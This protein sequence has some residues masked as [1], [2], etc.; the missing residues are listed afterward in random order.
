[1]ILMTNFTLHNEIV[2]RYIPRVYRIRPSMVRFIDLF[3]WD[4]NINI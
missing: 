2:K 4:D 3:G 1:M